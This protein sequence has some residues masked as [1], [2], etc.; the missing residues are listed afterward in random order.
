MCNAHRKDYTLCEDSALPESK[1]RFDK[2]IG[3]YS[4]IL[5]HSKNFVQSNALLKKNLGNINRKSKK[6]VV[7]ILVDHGVQ[8]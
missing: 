3:K 8:Y 4:D 2:M 5:D 1:Q 6:M 7:I